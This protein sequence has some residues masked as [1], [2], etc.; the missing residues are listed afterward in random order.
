[1][2]IGDYK[3]KVGD[4]VITI[5]GER[6]E[7]VYICDCDQC[8]ARGFHEPVWRNEY[9]DEEEEYISEYEAARGFR[10]YYKIGEYRFNKLQREWIERL[11]NKREVQLERLRNQYRVICEI[12]ERECI[13]ED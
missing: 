4:E 2:N 8:K 13:K 10:N 5:D 1:M 6:G 12:E 7:I 11:I 3:F 9:D